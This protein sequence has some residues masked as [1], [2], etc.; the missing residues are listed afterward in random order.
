MLAAAARPL[1]R[2]PKP[3]T[4]WTAAA[5]YARQRSFATAPQPDTHVTIVPTFTVPDGQMT[6]F[7]DLFPAFYKDTR[8]GT[9]KCL[10]YGFAISGD[11]VFCREGYADAEG[12]L[13]HA[14]D[15]GEP[16]GVALEMV[17]EGGLELAVMGPA[18]ELEKLKEAFEP[19]GARFWATDAGG[20][21]WGGAGPGA[22]PARSQP[23]PDTHVTIVPTFTVP[24]GQMTAFTD[25]FPAFYKD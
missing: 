2:L 3:A 19:L 1:A 22:Q 10:Y 15:V 23:Q 14:A 11:N 5:G 4:P 12:C 20:M 24:D 18:G 9:D 8:A 13:A 25:L 6:A 16:L 21:W 17:G 7:T